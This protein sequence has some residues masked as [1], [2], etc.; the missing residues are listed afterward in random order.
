MLAA[1]RVAVL[2]YPDGVPGGQAGDVGG[3]EVLA[4]NGNAHLEQG[5]Y[6]HKV[7]ALAARPVYSGGNDGEV[8]RHRGRRLGASPMYQIFYYH[9]AHIILHFCRQCDRPARLYTRPPCSRAPLAQ[10]SV[11]QVA[12][13]TGAPDTVLC[14]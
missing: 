13:P 7:C 14:R 1:R 5:A 4:V 10:A 2:A 9:I 12:Q 3:K 6:K 11:V 8:I